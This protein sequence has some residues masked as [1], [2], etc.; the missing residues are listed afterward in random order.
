MINDFKGTMKEKNL[1]KWTKAQ[2]GLVVRESSIPSLSQLYDF[3]RKLLSR[4]TKTVLSITVS[5]LEN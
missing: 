4:V 2:S 1:V 3:I 5:K